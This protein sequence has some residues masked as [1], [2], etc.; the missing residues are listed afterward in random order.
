MRYF[1]LVRRNLPKRLVR[2][3]EELFPLIYAKA[4]RLAT[5]EFE[6][7]RAHICGFIRW[8]LGDDA[9]FQAAEVADMPADRVY[10]SNGQ[11]HTEVYSDECITIVKKVQEP[12]ETGSAKYKMQRARNNAQLELFD[13]DLTPLELKEDERFLIELTHGPYPDDRSRLWFIYVMVCD[14]DGEPLDYFPLST[15]YPYEQSEDGGIEEVPDIPVII[16]K[17]GA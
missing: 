8:V 5:S 6:S 12:G 16:P 4:D 15:L 9:L 1:A 7:N 3:I 11:Q 14:G 17:K 2:A 13:D 10:A